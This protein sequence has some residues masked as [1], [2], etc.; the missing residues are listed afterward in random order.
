[1]DT[2]PK[3]LLDAADR[4]LYP[5]KQSGQNQVAIAEA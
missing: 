4:A 1:M 2:H 5:A 3:T